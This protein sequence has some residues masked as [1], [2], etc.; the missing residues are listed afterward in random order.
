MDPKISMVINC[1]IAALGV[2]V[3]SSAAFTTLF[4]SQE[5]TIIVTSAGLALAVLGAV[6]GIL[7]GYAKPLILFAFIAAGALVLGGEAR[8]QRARDPAPIQL[9]QLNLPK[10]LICDPL[11]LL[12]GCHVE[13]AAPDG[14][15]AVSTQPVE[16]DIWQKITQAALPDLAYASAQASAAGTD[17]SGVRKQC[18]DALIRANQQASGQGVKGADGTV[19]TKPDPHLFTD[20]ESLAEVLDNLAPNGP[21]WAACAGAAGLARTT[22]LTYINAVIGGAAGLA[23]LGV[24]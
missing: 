5:A 14:K 18:W 7:H 4:G 13:K 22:V 2:L 23:A 16:L 1:V 10:P 3:A 11:N 6:N 19:M 15:G 17:T 8:A 20:V 24:T 9:P 12:P 21:L